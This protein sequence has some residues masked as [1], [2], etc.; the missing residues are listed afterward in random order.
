MV[1]NNLLVGDL[2]RFGFQIA[3]SPS[4]ELIRKVS[5]FI[6]GQNLTPFDNSAYLPSFVSR[7]QATS[8]WLKGK[9]DYLKYEH[10][11]SGLNLTETH[12]TLVHNHLAILTDAEWDL[13]SKVHTFGDWGEITDDFIAFL[14]PYL[15]RLYL[16]Y[17][18]RNNGLREFDI[19][20]VADS[21]ETTPYEL[22]MTLDEAVSCLV[23]QK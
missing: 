18:L 15:D 20:D 21:I 22:I 10:L 2:N 6:G 16:T 17:Q 13:V 14:I 11:L 8:E 7:L 4:S 12:N 19:L 1:N 5:I 23:G 9:I 3:N